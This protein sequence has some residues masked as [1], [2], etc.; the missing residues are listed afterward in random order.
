MDWAGDSSHS[1]ILENE[2]CSPFKKWVSAFTFHKRQGESSL[3]RGQG[4]RPAS[5]SHGAVGWQHRRLERSTTGAGQLA[6]QQVL[7]KWTLA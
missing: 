6:A 4:P 3:W 7:G 2:F 5:H 1:L